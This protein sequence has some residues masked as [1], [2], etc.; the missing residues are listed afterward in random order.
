VNLRHLVTP[1]ADSGL[2]HFVGKLSGHETHQRLYAVRRPGRR[3]TGAFVGAVT[4]GAVLKL[5]FPGGDSLSNCLLPQNGGANAAITT[6][7]GAPMM[8]INSAMRFI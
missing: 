4:E 3:G 7:S 5:D 8:R 2:R 6:A 1:A